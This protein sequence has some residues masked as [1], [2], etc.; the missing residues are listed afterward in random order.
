MGL[1]LKKT[2]FSPSSSPSLLQ[3]LTDLLVMSSSEHETEVP[4]SDK[5]GVI[6][7]PE[8][9]EEAQQQTPSWQ[10]SS[11]RA[12]W[13]PCPG[14]HCDF[15]GSNSTPVWRRGPSGYFFLYLLV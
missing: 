1:F 11:V 2:T 3:D 4:Q 9:A 7:P 5:Q 15:C 10:S 13:P 6:E 14:R 8:Q 12:K